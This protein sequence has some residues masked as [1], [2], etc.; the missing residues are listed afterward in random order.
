MSSYFDSSFLVSLYSLD[1]NSARAAD[2]I[3]RS[4]TVRL[5]TTFGELEL[6][7]ALALRVF[8]R[9]LSSDDARLSFG[10]F[11]EDVRNGVFAVRPISEPMLERARELSMQTTPK[12]GTRTADLLHVAAALEV[13][14]EILYSF[15]ERQRKL[16][17][18]LKLK[19]Q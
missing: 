12:L 19:I 10:R 3:R 16:A 17:R 14:A 1:S 5:I 6:A 7:N 15:D 8:R 13:G 9:E 4:P 11:D 2:A 18:T